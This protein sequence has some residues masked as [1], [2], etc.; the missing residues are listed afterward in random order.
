MGRP[1]KYNTNN[2]RKL[3][4]TESD[5]LYR[6]AN[7]KNIKERH[8]THRL[9]NKTVINKRNKQ[10]KIDNPEKYKAFYISL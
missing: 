6:E 1:K 7:A 9:L 10:W 5:R 3:A 4:K 8:K 2:E